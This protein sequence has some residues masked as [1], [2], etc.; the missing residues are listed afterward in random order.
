M[1]PEVKGHPSHRSHGQPWLLTLM[2]ALVTLPGHSALAGKGPNCTYLLP[3]PKHA[4]QG[5]SQEGCRNLS[6]AWKGTSKVG[7]K[8]SLQQPS[9]RF[10]KSTPT[11][12]SQFLGLPW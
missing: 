1:N 3:C 12:H 9:V 6:S 11:F 8:G 10:A 2:P 5:K 7:N 4:H